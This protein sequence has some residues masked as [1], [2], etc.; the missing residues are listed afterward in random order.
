M[1]LLS[2]VTVPVMRPLASRNVVCADAVV[3]NMR[4]TSAAITA[5]VRTPEGAAYFGSTQPGGTPAGRHIR[6]VVA[7][8]Q[9]GP[10]RAREQETGLGGGI[11]DL[12]PTSLVAELQRSHEARLRGL[13]RWISLGG[14]N[15]SA[16]TGRL[17]SADPTTMIA[18][19]SASEV[20]RIS[21]VSRLGSSPQQTC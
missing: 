3:A 2:V 16:R 4:N 18:P 9:H 6:S 19:A 17:S 15:P 5:A 11:G 7:V 13:R 21:E 20:L 8:G 10:A 14:G 1:P 12:T